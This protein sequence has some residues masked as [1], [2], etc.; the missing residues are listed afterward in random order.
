ML[1]IAVF[2]ILATTTAVGFAIKP[3]L[4]S[5]PEVTGEKHTNG[6]EDNGK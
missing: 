2:A 4:M 3:W 6:P 5:E 1:A